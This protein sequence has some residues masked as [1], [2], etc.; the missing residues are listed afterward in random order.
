MWGSG[1]CLGSG[2]IEAFS[3]VPKIVDELSGIRIADIAV[4]DTHCL[5]LTQ[6]CTVYAWGLNNMGQCGLG[7]ANSPICTPQKIRFEFIRY[8][9]KV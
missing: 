2:S 8:Y 9:Y 1:A 6:D 5:A 7:H 4:G 3:L